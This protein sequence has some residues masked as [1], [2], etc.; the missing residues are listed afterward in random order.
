MTGADWEILGVVAAGLGIV[1]LPVAI[2]TYRRFRAARSVACPASGA[3]AGVRVDAFS[4]A[5]GSAFDRLPLKVASC[6][7][8]PAKKGCGE[9]CVAAFREERAPAVR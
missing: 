2:G 1:V 5:I 4:A 8:W 9:E 7:L 3:I 6:S